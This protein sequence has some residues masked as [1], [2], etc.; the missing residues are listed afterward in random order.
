MGF[1]PP[2]VDVRAGIRIW[3]TDA[4]PMPP[5]S[6]SSRIDSGGNRRQ[7]SGGHPAPLS[8]RGR[9]VVRRRAEGEERAQQQVR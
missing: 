7:A 2:P 9:D 6:R 8:N 4:N 1:L 3:R 5:A